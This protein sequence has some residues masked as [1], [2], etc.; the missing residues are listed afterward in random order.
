MVRGPRSLPDSTACI[1]PALAMLSSTMR[2]TPSADPTASMSSFDPI[3]PVRASFE[4]LR[5]ELD[6]PL[7]EGVGHDIAQR[8]VAV[9]H[10]RIG[11][12]THEGDRAGLG[13]GRF[14]APRS[15][16]PTGRRRRSSRPPA[17]ISII[18]IT[19]MRT[20]MPEPLMKRAAR[21]ISNLRA[22][23][24]AWQLSIRQSLAVVPP[25]SKDRTSLQPGLTR[26]MRAARMAPPAG[27]IRPAGWGNAPRSP[28][29]SCR[30]RRSSS[31]SGK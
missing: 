12:A 29:W 10:G 5:V 1:R 26:A 27:P 18:S 28:A 7:G 16:G 31:G 17:P 3:T 24:G 19:G 20:G 13:S 8:D 22:R 6:M 14:A 21:A 23:S 4:P 15:G 11:A 9:G 2:L 30:R 25:I